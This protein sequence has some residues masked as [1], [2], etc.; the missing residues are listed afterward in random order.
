MSHSGHHQ[1]DAS[2]SGLP[3]S[4]SRSA[5]KGGGASAMADAPFT[6]FELELEFVQSL[7]NPLYLNCAPPPP[8]PPCN[9]PRAC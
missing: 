9:A 6:R 7:G 3:Q 1:Q 2:A 5:E 4:Q 8:I